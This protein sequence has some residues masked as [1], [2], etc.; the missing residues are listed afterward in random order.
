LRRL[1]LITDA[2]RSR[3]LS[4]ARLWIVP[5]LLFLVPTVTSAN[6]PI[7]WT[8]LATTNKEY[9]LKLVTVADGD[10]TATTIGGLA[11]RRNTTPSN[12]FYM[13][14]AVDNSFAYQGNRP[15]MFIT[16]HYWDGPASSFRVEYD[17]STA[18]Y[19]A[20]PWISTTGTNTWKTYTLGVKNAYFGNRQNGGA[21]LRIAATPGTTFYLDLVYVREILPRFPSVMF[22]PT[23]HNANSYPTN[24]LAVC[25]NPGQWS[26]GESN[27]DFFGSV[28]WQLVNGTN[29]ALTSCFNNLRNLG[30]RFTVEVPALKEWEGCWTGQSCFNTTYPKLDR[31]IGLG[32]QVDAI[33]LDE[34]LNAVLNLRNPSPGRSFAIQQ[35]ALYMKLMR[36]RYVHT[37]IMSIEP[38]P[39][40][41]SAQLLAWVVDLNAECAKIGTPIMDIMIVDHDIAAG[42]SISS[43]GS[44]KSSVTSLGPRFG[45]AFFASNPTSDAQYYSKVMSQGLA[46]QSTLLDLY[47]VTSWDLYPSAQV[48]EATTYTFTYTLIQ[49]IWNRVW[50]R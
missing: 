19:H 23:Y 50:G 6:V 33:G 30:K 32:A 39:T 4:R 10:T 12:D 44:L 13:Y 34:P 27:T 15:N 21:D 8:D 47:W 1:T 48:P 9:K 26:A 7:V 42:G 3:I 41:S 43:I 31:L 46:Y 35:T 36:Q 5:A 45:V 24:F 40:F 37:Q 28:D 22:N 2:S 17:S 11:S 20:G 18:A 29:S 25:L 49:F 16:F 38:Y 14:F